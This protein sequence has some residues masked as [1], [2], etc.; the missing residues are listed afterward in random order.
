[1]YRL[2]NR[3]RPHPHTP[4]TIRQCDNP[5]SPTQRYDTRTAHSEQGHTPGEA[6]GDVRAVHV[7]QV[8]GG[9]V[10]VTQVV[11]VVEIQVSILTPSHRDGGAAR[12]HRGGR[13]AGAMPST[14]R[15][16]KRAR[17]SGKYGSSGA[18][19]SR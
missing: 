8:V 1:M 7:I 10:G 16:P 4:S 19:R 12:A 3:A 18:M 14:M 17:S 2:R 5:Q 11:R 15:L 13:A 6:Q 9:V